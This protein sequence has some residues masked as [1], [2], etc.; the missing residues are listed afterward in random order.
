MG[1]DTEEPPRIEAGPRNAGSRSSSGT[2][3][4][5]PPSVSVPSAVSS[6]RIGV[7]QAAQPTGI[8][9]VDAQLGKPP[10]RRPGGMERSYW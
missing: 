9:P 1:W 3:L 2:Q 4:R 6:S 8:G 5:E 7:A 10:T